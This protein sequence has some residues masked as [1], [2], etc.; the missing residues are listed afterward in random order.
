LSQPK[1]LGPAVPALVEDALE[2]LQRRYPS[3]TQG[4][5]A[6]APLGQLLEAFWARSEARREAGPEPARVVRQLACVGGTIFARALQAQPNVV[7]L[8]EVDPFA[9]RPPRRRP[10]FAPTDLLYLAELAT[11]SVDDAVREEVFCAGVRAL[12]AAYERQGVRLIVRAH[13]HT[14]YCTSR[15]W[16]SRP[17]VTE[18]LA[19]DMPVRVL[20]LVRHPLD[21]WLALNANGWVHFQ[22][23][24]LEE[25]ARRYLHFVDQPRG[26]PVLQYEDFT[27][28]PDGV[29]A[30]VCEWLDL[31]FN[32]GWR[33]LIAAI[34]LTGASG[35]GGD[36]IAPR[37]R[38]PVPDAIAAQAAA[39]PSY[40]QLC[41][42]LGY[43]PDPAGAP[44]PVSGP[45]QSGA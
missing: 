16:S 15:E 7:V 37:P 18:L 39:S 26:G 21:S 4:G 13:S 12:R 25:Y 36:V 3:P 31:A 22:P 34:R 27:R 9:T 1:T 6:G 19:R 29:L 44:L 8:S 28:D 20:T 33:D 40:D 38:Q 24:T 45:A 30:L 32:P 17:G 41:A 2:L 42:R 23:A 43:D 35:R 14:R 5:A 11:G 10:E